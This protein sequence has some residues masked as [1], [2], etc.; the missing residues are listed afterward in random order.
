MTRSINITCVAFTALFTAAVLCVMTLKGTWSGF[1]PALDTLAVLLVQ[2]LGY[3]F[4]RRKSLISFAFSFIPAL[5][6]L[7]FFLTGKVV[8][9]G[10]SAALLV[11][12]ALVYNIKH[13]ALPIS[14]FTTQK[15]L[16]GLI[17]AE[18]MLVPVILLILR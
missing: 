8:W 12:L 10:V 14:R 16:T 3:A 9:L 2:I 17:L 13:H 4:T 7:G 11:T 18:V 5:P 1:S 15:W 6:L